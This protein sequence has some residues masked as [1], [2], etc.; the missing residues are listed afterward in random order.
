MLIDM[1]ERMDEDNIKELL[2]YAVFPDPEKLEETLDEY[3]SNDDL[4]LLALE[5]DG[6]LIGI[7]GI[8]MHYK[9]IEIKHIAVQPHYR[10]LGYGRGLI[11]ELIA[12]ID[13]EEI[14]AETD[15][16]GVEFYRSIG[17]TISSLGEEF[18][19]V[20]RFKCVYYTNEQ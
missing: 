4:E 8:E 18:P 9:I 12:L 6:E 10:G 19:G 17:F 20:E 15:E 5:G 14:F 2:S 16:E 1:K 7:I 13:P 11:L 3:R